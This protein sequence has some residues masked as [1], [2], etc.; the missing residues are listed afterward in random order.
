FSVFVARRLPDSF[1]CFAC[2]GVE[3]V[4]DLVVG[5]HGSSPFPWLG[6]RLG[7]EPTGGYLRYPLSKPLIDMIR[8]A[9]VG[10]LDDEPAGLTAPRPCKVVDSRTADLG[11]GTLV[12]AV[13]VVSAPRLGGWSTH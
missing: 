2:H 1:F 9:T 13:A 12:P 10:I 4:A 5:T 8:P 11:H 3:L 6:C 7:T